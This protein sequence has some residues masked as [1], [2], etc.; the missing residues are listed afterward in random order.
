M[1]TFEILLSN[2]F[3]CF[4]RYCIRSQNLFRLT[5]SSVLEKQI[6]FLLA[7]LQQ[8]NIDVFILNNNIPAFPFIGRIKQHTGSRFE[9]MMLHTT[10]N[11]SRSVLSVAL[12]AAHFKVKKARS[13]R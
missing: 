11:K 5:Y 10:A 3:L 9:F 13:I 8:V 1:S 12:T 7:Y 6:Y 2:K 4:F